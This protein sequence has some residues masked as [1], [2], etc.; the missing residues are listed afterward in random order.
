[1]DN[2]LLVLY[3]DNGIKQ[4]FHKCF[5]ESGIQ[6]RSWLK[7]TAAFIVFRLAK[8]VKKIEKMC[9]NSLYYYPEDYEGLIILFDTK[10]PDIYLRMVRQKNPDARII[11][12]YWNEIQSQ[13]RL[14]LAASLGIDTWSY[15][16]ADC[17]KYD[18]LYNSQFLF[19]SVA[20]RFRSLRDQQE[21]QGEKS[22]I[23]IGREKGRADQ[24]R[25]ISEEIQKCGWGCETE[26]RS[27]Y[28][29][30]RPKD[31]NLKYKIWC[32]YDEYI[33][34]VLKYRGIL[35]VAYQP[36]SGLSLRTLESIFFHKKLITTNPLVKAYEFY[37]E[38]NIY[39]WGHSDM[40]LDEFLSRPYR[41][42]PDSICQTYLISSW[43][44]RFF[45][46]YG[47]NAG[48]SEQLNSGS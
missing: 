31:K 28:I 5:I 32:H 17:K 9:G 30:D 41:P 7:N 8:E 35:D 40:S 10:L 22:F 18:L 23:F 21:M 48:S 39:V 14:K 25:M 33:D 45:T 44:S 42:V 12:W 2:K 19:D 27:S 36:N 46:Y 1:M 26:F 37:D 38:N 20:V 3:Y 6:C 24:I 13:S 43:I 34:L 16:P 47:L 15:S 4:I 11:L 29:S